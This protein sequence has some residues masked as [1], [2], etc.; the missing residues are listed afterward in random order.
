MAVFVTGFPGFLTSR[1]VKQL[2][3][4]GEE[5]IFALVLQTEWEKAERRMEELLIEVG[6]SFRIELVVGDITQPDLGLDQQTA[7]RL[8]DEVEFVWHLAAI[9]DLAVPQDVAKKVNVTGTETVNA[10][11]RQLPKL[12]RYMYFSTAYVAGRRDG[13]LREDELIRPKS[14]KNHYEETKFEAELLVEEL[15]G[16]LPITIIR[17]GI[18]RGDSV[19]GETIKFDGPY[20]FLIMIDRL[21]KLPIIPYVGRSYSTINVVPVDYI[22]N[23]S[24]YLCYLEDAENHTVHL[25]DPRPYP[26]EEVYRAMVFGLTGKP[27]TGRIPLKMARAGLS[28]K[29][30][31]SLLGVEQ[32][33]LDYLTWN[34]NFDTSN[35]ERLLKDSGIECADFL[36]TM[37][38]MI[39]FY[40]ANRNKKEFFIEIK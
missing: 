25:T 12:K 39:Q 20:F 6:G 22:V 21:R 37:R 5:K 13:V 33:T 2:L 26:V 23:A 8:K 31:R 34:A 9:Y 15:K 16:E 27:P 10:F 18:V 28:V 24:I 32:E 1:I 4:R 17:P 29:S 19:T 7:Q 11:V 38:P 40:T 35:A 14:F 36:S 3:N 30:I